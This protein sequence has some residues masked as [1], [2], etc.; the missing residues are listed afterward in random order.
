MAKLTLD[1]YLLHKDVSKYLSQIKLTSVFYADKLIKKTGYSLLSTVAF[2]LKQSYKPSTEYSNGLRKI[3]N[4]MKNTQ[5]NIVLRV[6]YDCS[7]INT[8]SEYKNEI[9]SIWIP[10]FQEMHG[11]N[12]IQLVRYKFDQLLDTDQKYHNGL[13]GTIVRLIP[14]FNFNEDNKCKLVVC[15]DIDS[16]SGFIKTVYGIDLVNKWNYDIIFGTQLCQTL[17]DRHVFTYLDK[18]SFDYRIMA[19]IFYSK[20][21]FD[22]DILKTFLQCMIDNCDI[23]TNWLT[24]TLKNNR[25][26][27]KIANTSQHKWVYGIDEF[28]INRFM[29]INLLEIKA[30]M[31]FFIIRKALDKPFH[32][33]QPIIRSG[34][35]KV[36]QLWKD[37]LKKILKEHYVDD[38]DKCITIIDNILFLPRNNNIGYKATKEITERY[39]KELLIVAKKQAKK[40]MI[41]DKALKCIIAN[42]QHQLSQMYEVKYLKGTVVVAPAKGKT[43]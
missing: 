26:S 39:S 29:L 10:L 27:R 19:G 41:P 20:L 11:M 3:I 12:N 6:Y 22:K 30:N 16:I 14:M 34:S 40:Y 8:K 17:A 31:S 23:Y 18:Y 36:K 15:V 7:I 21:K 4:F 13:F 38:L 9:S 42:S 33:M 5:K 2:K 25:K 32:I 1:N 35:T 43:I 24:H 28:F 37:L